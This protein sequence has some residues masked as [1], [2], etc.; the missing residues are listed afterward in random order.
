MMVAPSKFFHLVR[1]SQGRETEGAASSLKK[2][3]YRR[4]ATKSK[5]MRIMDHIYLQPR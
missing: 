2:P 3:S 5:E 1:I 4:P